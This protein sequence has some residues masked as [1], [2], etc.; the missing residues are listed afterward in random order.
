MGFIIKISLPI[1][2]LIAFKSN[3]VVEY[4]KI[5]GEP[6]DIKAVRYWMSWVSEMTFKTLRETYRSLMI[7]WAGA[8][9]ATCRWWNKRRDYLAIYIYLFLNFVASSAEQ[10]TSTHGQPMRLPNL[11]GSC[12]SFKIDGFLREVDGCALSIHNDM[13]LPQSDPSATT[14]IGRYTVMNRVVATKALWAE[15][16]KQSTSWREPPKYNITA[17]TSVKNRGN[18]NWVFRRAVSK[19]YF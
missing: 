12:P 4:G 15:R 6:I 11:S 8:V 1:E 5:E 14:C 16:A 18:R 19:T 10:D 13:R 9:H 3:A 2:Y 17:R 7:G